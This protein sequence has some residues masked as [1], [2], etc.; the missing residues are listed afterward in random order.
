MFNVPGGRVNS[1]RNSFLSRIQATCNAL[2]KEAPE[3][4]FFYSLSSFRSQVF[5][6]AN[7]AGTGWKEITR[8]SLV[9]QRYSVTSQPARGFV[10][11]PG[12]KWRVCYCP[13]QC[14]V[15]TTRDW[16]DCDC[17]VTLPRAQFLPD[18]SRESS[19][20]VEIPCARPKRH[21]IGVATTSSFSWERD[22]WPGN[23][24][25]ASSTENL[26][27]ILQESAN[28]LRTVSSIEQL[29]RQVQKAWI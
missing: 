14:P 21:K 23:G 5:K 11:D 7:S 27:A 4:D 22:V 17:D 9:L 13:V 12:I 15:S 1:V 20:P 29:T 19:C 3:T 28:E 6:F 24:T 25:Q 2:L 8:T 18:V 26:W 10:F 16:R